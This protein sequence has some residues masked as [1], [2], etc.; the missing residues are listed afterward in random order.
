MVVIKLTVRPY[1][2]NG[3][4]NGTE[5][6]KAIGSSSKI[7]PRAPATWR[8]IQNQNGV[9]KFHLTN[10]SDRILNETTKP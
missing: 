2:M 3:G 5:R 10:N 8:K 7:T 6:S 1:L 9:K 4:N